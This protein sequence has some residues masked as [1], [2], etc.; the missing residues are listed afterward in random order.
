MNIVAELIVSET[1]LIQT[2]F[3]VSIQESLAVGQI[4]RLKQFEAHFASGKIDS[5]E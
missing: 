4:F 1:E 5:Y 3:W 2:E